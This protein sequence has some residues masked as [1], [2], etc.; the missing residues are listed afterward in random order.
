MR[1]RWVYAIQL[2]LSLVIITA[3]AVGCAGSP[4]TSTPSSVTTPPASEYPADI[5]GRVTIAETVKAKYQSGPSA[6]ETMDMTPLEGQIYWIVD[7]SVKN[8]SYEKAVTAGSSHWKIVA[9]DEV[10]DAQSPFMSIQS[11]YPMTVSVGETGE[12]TI[13]FPVPDTLKVSSAKLCYQ[14]QEPYS[15]GKLTGGDKVAAYDWDSKT[16]IEQVVGKY[17]QYFVKREVTGY[18]KV[19]KIGNVDITEPI[20]KDIYM[21]LKTIMHWEKEDSEPKLITFHIS[22]APWVV[23]WGYQSRKLTALDPIGSEATFD[24]AIYT[25]ATYEKYLHG[26]TLG[27]IG[28][29]TGEDRGISSS[30][31]GCI[32]VQNAGDYVIRM[33]AE[34]PNN[35]LYWWIKI[36]ME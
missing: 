13:R 14:G 16:V 24:I 33:S 5:S 27:L 9:D 20:Y 30:G 10:Y 1:K 32:I 36:G 23:N 3:L 34:N 21:E 8:K 22:Q 18:K 35:L 17:E 28:L 6:G 12:T 15:Y 7:I 31:I 11:A 29:S 4:S 19:G 26:Q 25:K 2:I